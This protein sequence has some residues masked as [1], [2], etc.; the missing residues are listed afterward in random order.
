MK[1]I[2]EKYSQVNQQYKEENKT[3]ADLVLRPL[4]CYYSQHNRDMMGAF[5]TEE[6]KADCFLEKP[7]P[8]KELVSLLRLVNLLWLDNFKSNLYRHNFYL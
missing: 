1:M 7:L 8:I 6:E 4:M 3:D 5:T 2:K